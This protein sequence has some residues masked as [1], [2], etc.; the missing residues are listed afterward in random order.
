MIEKNIKKKFFVGFVITFFGLIVIYLS[1]YGVLRINLPD[2]FTGKIEIFINNEKTKE[3]TI[4]KNS[5]WFFSKK[6]NVKARITSIEK[7]TIIYDK[8]NSFGIVNA[9][10]ELNQ[11]KNL[12]I[13]G[14]STKKCSQ[15]LNEVVLYFNCNNYELLNGGP[16]LQNGTIKTDINVE[17][18]NAVYKGA[19]SSIYVFYKTASNVLTA[20][21]IN[22]S[23]NTLNKVVDFNNFNG[24]V[25][26]NNIF[27][28]K[29]TSQITVF[30][31]NEGK[32]FI[33]SKDKKNTSIIDA[34]GKFVQSIDTQQIVLSANNDVY[35]INATSPDAG[36]GDD[37]HDNNGEKNNKNP[38]P[39]QT[40]FKWS[41][42]S[43]SW[44]EKTIIN[45]NIRLDFVD[46]NKNGSIL[47][48]N[49]FSKE[50]E[51]Y[52]YE[53]NNL[54]KIFEPFNGDGRFC[55]DSE[56]SFIYDDIIEKGIYR[57]NIR[58]K[59]S[60]LL[61]RGDRVNSI[62]I[63]CDTTIGVAFKKDVGDEK[64]L[65]HFVLTDASSDGKKL[66]NLLPIFLPSN[67][68]V[69]RVDFY[70]KVA[71]INVIFKDEPFLESDYLTLKSQLFNILT[72]NKID[73]Q[74]L[75]IVY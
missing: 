71:K 65:L 2:N 17:A 45:K 24:T 27:V 9:N 51:L 32:I 74:N 68:G 38:Y 7:T 1:N 53:N 52:L 36:L 47:L 12:Q 20:F 54:K 49:L 10:A 28:D 4:Q 37:D 8:L 50:P 26:E 33:Y 67:K 43:G 34:K 70:Y 66:E 30:D 18:I 73:S 31:I 11:L 22:P 25:L 42:K 41:K 57:F 63:T 16:E 58:T 3:T 72:K 62:F 64:N 46:I 29:M 75:S 35:L 48:N 56:S 21:L 6:G 61:Y 44:G 19:A 39:E 60:H 5:I 69:V 55:F 59:Q 23:T 40:I 13:L 15:L 14:S